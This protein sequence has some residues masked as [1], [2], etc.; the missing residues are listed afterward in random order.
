M[1]PKCF[2][3]L[4]LLLVTFK[5][6]IANSDSLRITI[7]SVFKLVF[8]S[9]SNNPSFQHTKYDEVIAE[10]VYNI[11]M[12]KDPTISKEKKMDLLIIMSYFNRFAADILSGKLSNDLRSK[13]S[14][15]EIEII[16]LL[17]IAFST[18][19]N[20]E[21]HTKSKLIDSSSINTQF[22]N[23]GNKYKTY[24]K[25]VLSMIKK[26]TKKDEEKIF[27]QALADKYIFIKSKSTIEQYPQLKKLLDQK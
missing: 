3:I 11:V 7:D 22:R 23:S 17:P 1:K 2:F 16:Q 6:T 5:G 19:P 10:R 4:F 13:S 8:S 18:A 24:C 9:A 20:F 25:L 27:S 12:S 26:Y 15:T 21:I 14:V